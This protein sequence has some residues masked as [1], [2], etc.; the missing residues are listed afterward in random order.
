MMKSMV[1]MCAGI[2]V[3]AIF[4]A[5][6]A[7]GQRQMEYLG[8]GVVAVGQGN[9]GVYVGWRMLGTDPEEVAFNVYRDGVRVN[10][11]P[12]TESTNVIDEEG[13]ADSVYTVRAVVDGVEGEASG[14]V[15]VWDKN[16]LSIPLQGP[17]GCVPNDASVGDLDGDGEYEIVL[18]QS[19]RGRDNASR[20]RT[21][22]PIFEAYRLDGTLMWRLNLGKNIREGAHYTQFMVYDLDGDGRAEFVCKTADGTVDGAGKVI[23]DADADWV[24]SDGKILEGPEFLTVFDGRNGAACLFR[25]HAP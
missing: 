14:E 4:L 8:W 17:A 7:G 23:G 25:R 21:G 18:H 16:Y 13:S 19:P 1:K 3:G 12:I 6:A 24:N 5:G 2:L 15:K 20:G 9:S 10:S 22:E 11:Q